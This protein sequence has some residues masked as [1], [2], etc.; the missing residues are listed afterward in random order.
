[1]QPPS[2][3]V[4]PETGVPWA[5]SSRR[6]VGGQA[7]REVTRPLFKGGSLSKAP[8]WDTT[9][10]SAGTERPATGS[11]AAEPRFVKTALTKIHNG[12]W[13]DEPTKNP[14][15]NWVESTTRVRELSLPGK[16]APK[17]YRMGYDPN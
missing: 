4:P 5:K 16:H 1:M 9:G 7:S 15:Y 2:A 8:F 10:T 13:A 12:V 17:L 11:G 14:G 3:T 6:F